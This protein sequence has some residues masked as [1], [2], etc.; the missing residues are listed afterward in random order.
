MKI[1]PYD[2]RSIANNGGTE[3]MR[4]ALCQGADEL[5]ALEKQL[6]ILCGIF[7]T[8]GCNCHQCVSFRR[9]LE[10]GRKI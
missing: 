1:T 7:L 4:I 3:H 5:Q 6:N 8:P 2:M 9:A 10:D